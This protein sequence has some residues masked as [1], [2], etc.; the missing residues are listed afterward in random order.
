MLSI[1]YRDRFV[2]QGRH[3]CRYHLSFPL[4]AAIFDGSGSRDVRVPKRGSCC[5][6]ERV[7]HIPRI[8]EHHEVECQEPCFSAGDDTEVW[9]SQRGVREDTV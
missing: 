7:I 4:V 9:R 8:R 3:P 6:E 2:I 5:H 1:L